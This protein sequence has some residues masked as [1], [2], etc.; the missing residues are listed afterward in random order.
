V[1]TNFKAAKCPPASEEDRY[2]TALIDLINQ[3]RAAKP[4][5]P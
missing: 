3:K 5:T 1:W 2:E 4:I